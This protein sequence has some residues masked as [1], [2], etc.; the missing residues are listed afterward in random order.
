MKT[1]NNINT[2]DITN[3]EVL[4]KPIEFLNEEDLKEKQVNAKNTAELSI[5]ELYK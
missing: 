1:N 2:V 4:G 3:Y 5:K